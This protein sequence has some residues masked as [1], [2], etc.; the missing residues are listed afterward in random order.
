MGNG[1]CQHVQPC[2]AVMW[3]KYLSLQLALELGQELDTGGTA[4]NYFRSLTII[5][6]R[7]MLFR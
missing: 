2:H 7:T 4:V 5:N 1:P 3:P 6:F